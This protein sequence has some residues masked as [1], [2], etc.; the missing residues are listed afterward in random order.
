MS[1]THYGSESNGCTTRLSKFPNSAKAVTKYARLYCGS[2]KQIT[3]NGY[4]QESDAYWP[5]QQFYKL[6]KEDRDAIVE[7]INAI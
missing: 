2:M 4:S 7:F 6:P 1:V 5:T 3:A